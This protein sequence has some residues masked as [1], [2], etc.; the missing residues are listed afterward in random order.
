MKDFTL[1]IYRE[2]LETL[3]KQGY[4]VIF[5][6]D[7]PYDSFLFKAIALQ[8]VKFVK[9]IVTKYVDKHSTC[10]ILLNGKRKL[11]YEIKNLDSIIKKDYP[12]F[13]RSKPFKEFNN[14]AKGNNL[15]YLLKLLHLLHI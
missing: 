10:D 4:D 13:Q 1:D 15:R 11:K 5:Y 14:A 7:R 2:L 6:D 12:D 9:K 8:N 3:Q